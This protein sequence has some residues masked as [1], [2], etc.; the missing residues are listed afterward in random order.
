MCY[1]LVHLDRREKGNEELYEKICSILGASRLVELGGKTKNTFRVAG[2]IIGNSA[3]G[4][5][6][7]KINNLPCQ[8]REV[9]IVT[10]RDDI[11]EIVRYEENIKE[12]HPCKTFQ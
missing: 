9:L 5:V 4:E 7:K 11:E 2:E 3:S 1:A 12:L 8:I 10:A 6:K